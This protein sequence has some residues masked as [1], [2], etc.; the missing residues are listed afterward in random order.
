MAATRNIVI[1]QGKTFGRVL[2]WEAPPVIYKAISAITNT[3][4]ARL[5]V[6]GHGVP[7]LWRVAV[8]SVKGMKQINAEN[9]PRQNEYRQATVIDA[10]TIELNGVNASDYGVYAS[11]G[12]IQ[13]NTPVS[14]AGYD[15]RMSIKDKVG[16]TELLRLDTTNSRIVLDDANKTITI[17]VA[18]DDTESITWVRGVYDLELVSPSGRVYVL[19]SGTVIVTREVTST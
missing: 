6:A 11:G 9:P 15:A 4:P 2:R 3:A 19:L 13:Y 18:A 8:V 12:Y 17:E 14:L 5:T 1:N 7:P 16:G 10:N